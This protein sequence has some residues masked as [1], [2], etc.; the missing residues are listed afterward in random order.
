MSKT[1]SDRPTPPTSP[2]SPTP[3]YC[4]AFLVS[5]IVLLGLLV[6]LAPSVTF[7]DAGE[8]IAAMKT[9][10]IP[11]PPGTPLF[12][13]MGHVFGSAFPF[14]ESAFRTNLLSGLFASAAA[15]FWFLVLHET[16]RSGIGCR[17]SGVGGREIANRQS[18]VA[19]RQSWSPVANRGSPVANRGVAVGSQENPDWRITIGDWRT[20]DPCRAATKVISSSYNPFGATWS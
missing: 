11:H 12:V 16:I 13:L 9:L 7:W 18:W 6:S 14:G 8:F 1:T 3:P 4:W 20:R 17:G 5:G 19:S 15:G 10:G 2:T